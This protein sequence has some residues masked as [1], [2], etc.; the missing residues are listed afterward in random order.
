MPVSH[1]SSASDSYAVRALDTLYAPRLAGKPCPTCALRFREEAAY[2]THIDWHFAQNKAAGK[3]GRSHHVQSRA[4]YLPVASWHAD[5]TAEAGLAVATPFEAPAKPGTA[6]SAAAGAEEQVAADPNF[7]TCAICNEPFE[8][9]WD[10]D[11]N[12]WV[13][14][15]ATRIEAGGIAHVECHKK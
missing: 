7:K 8:T 2:K 4:W 3:T 5:A 9:V 10:E 14:R 11:D 15:S 12:E 6:A 13:Y 1:V